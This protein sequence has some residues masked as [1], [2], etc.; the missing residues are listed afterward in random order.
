MRLMIA[1]LILIFVWIIFRKCRKTQGQ[2]ALPVETSDAARLGRKWHNPGPCK[3]TID[4]HFS[5][6]NAV[7]EAYKQRKAGPDRRAL[8]ERLAWQHLE[9]FPNLR[10]ILIEWMKDH[11][12]E[13]DLD[14]S[15]YLPHI[16][17]FEYLATSLTEKGEYD[18][19]VEVCRKAMSY[20]LTDMTKTGYEGRIERVLEGVREKL[21]AH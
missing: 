16:P 4:R 11:S 3:A 17:T 20:G 12:D 1:F 14:D 5:L 2:P 21:I 6:L 18:Q 7:Q 9:E 13:K 8:L 15:M 10:P 19:A